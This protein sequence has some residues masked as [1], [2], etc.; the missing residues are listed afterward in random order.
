MRNVYVVADNIFSPLGRN[1][2]TNIEALKQGRSGIQLHTGGLSPDPFYASLF[3]P[4]GKIAEGSKIFFEQIVLESA[5]DALERA[6][7]EPGDK[8][9]G[10]I[11][12]TTKG[13]ISLI[14]NL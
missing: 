7:I 10:F 14:E 5:R 8:K 9:T 2:I 4:S 1:T 12:S 6:R 3:T 13:N 11:L